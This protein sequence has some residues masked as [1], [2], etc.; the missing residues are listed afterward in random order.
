MSC[1]FGFKDS[2][3]ITIVLRND[4]GKEWVET[5]SH[6]SLSDYEVWY[7]NNAFHIIRLGMVLVE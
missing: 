2:Y 4:E 7:G 6:M 5:Y 3:N 1:N